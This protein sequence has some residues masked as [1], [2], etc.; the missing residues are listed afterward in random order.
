V[1]TGPAQG[2]SIA[3]MVC[4][5][6]GLLLALFGLGFLV[7]VAA[8]I[9]GHIAQRKQPYARPFWLTGL[10]TGYVGVGIGAI[11]IIFFV[12]IFFAALSAGLN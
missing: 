10:I 7:S 3:S 12:A 4:G 8:V 5:I 11:T 6:A 1:A 9:T 2:L